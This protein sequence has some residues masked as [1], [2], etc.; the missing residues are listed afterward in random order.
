MKCLKRL[1]MRGTGRSTSGWSR[2]ENGRFSPGVNFRGTHVILLLKNEVV[3]NPPVRDVSLRSQRIPI[4]FGT[5]LTHTG[6]TVTTG[7]L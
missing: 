6:T 2:P 5:V 7:N 4:A 3:A 1:T